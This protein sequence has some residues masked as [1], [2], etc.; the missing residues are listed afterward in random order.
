MVLFIL[1]KVHVYD[2]V[3]N[4]Y[5]PICEQSSKCNSNLQTVILMHN[6]WKK[7]FAFYSCR[8]EED[9]ID[10]Y[11]FQSYPSVSYSRRWQVPGVYT[12]IPFHQIYMDC[13]SLMYING[14]KICHFF[15]LQSFT[16]CFSL[17][18]FRGYVS[19]L[20]LSPNLRKATA[21]KVD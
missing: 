21:P 9:K 16:V 5:E 13:Q 14:Y 10:S 7:C 4:K 2:L 20:K 18:N 6:G 19:S 15:H 3:V 11:V 12:G 1:L 17:H 8:K